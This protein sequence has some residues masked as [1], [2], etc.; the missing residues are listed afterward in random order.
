MLVVGAFLVPNGAVDTNAPLSNFAVRLD[1]LEAVTGIIFFGSGSTTLNSSNNDCITSSYLTDSEKKKLDE[2]VPAE[3][4]ISSL[5]CMTGYHNN[6][7]QIFDHMNSTLLHAKNAEGDRNKII[8]ISNMD[9]HDVSSVH[10]NN[11]QKVG[12]VVHLCKCVDCWKPLELYSA[13][14]KK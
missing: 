6:E 3:N 10:K 13:V 9:I 2:S 11:N 12:T 8:N 4:D 7:R 14:K 5:L 1:D